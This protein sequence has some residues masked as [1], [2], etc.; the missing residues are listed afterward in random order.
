MQKNFTPLKNLTFLLSMMRDLNSVQ[1]AHYPKWLLLV[2][3]S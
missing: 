1:L 3:I 2:S